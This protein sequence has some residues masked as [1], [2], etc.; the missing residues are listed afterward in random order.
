MKK[1]SL[2]KAGVNEGMRLA[3]VNGNT[4]T[5]YDYLVRMV[6]SGSVRELTFKSATTKELC[7]VLRLNFK[8]L[9]KYKGGWGRVVSTSKYPKVA[10]R[11]RDSL[12]ISDLEAKMY[13]SVKAVFEKVK[14]TV[15]DSLVRN[16]ADLSY[17]NRVVAAWSTAAELLQRDES[18]S[19]PVNIINFKEG[20]R[21]LQRLI[22][23]GLQN[24]STNVF[25]YL[26]LGKTELVRF[27]HENHPSFFLRFSCPIFTAVR[28]A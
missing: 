19:L 9:K 8:D 23:S 11:I 3:S 7:E 22:N 21:D 25:N 27:W 12:N 2:L 20:A 1:D 6:E 28:T 14:K 5:D 13:A 18:P 16:E 10:D 24:M 4:V 26:R 17:A 15:T